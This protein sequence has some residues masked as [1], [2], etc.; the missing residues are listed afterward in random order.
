[1]KN[2]GVQGIG[3]KINQI[4]TPLIQTNDQ[5]NFIKLDGR[6]GPPKL[7]RK[8][9]TQLCPLSVIDKETLKLIQVLRLHTAIDHTVSVT[10]SAVLLRSLVQPRTDLFYIRSKQESLKEIASNAK[11]RKA[12]QDFVH[13]Y[14]RG[15]SALYKFLNKDLYAISP[16]R[17]LKKARQSSAAMVKMMQTIP[18]AETSYLRGLMANLHAYDGSP[19]DQMMRGSIYKTFKGLRSDKQVGLFTPKLKFIP[20][21]FSKWLPA[22]P[23]VAV[24]PYIFNHIGFEPSLSPLMSIIGLAW[25][26]LYLFYSLIVKPVKDTGNFIEPLRA[27]CIHDKAFSRAVDTVGMIDE[28]LS[29]HCW[30]SQ[31]SHATTLPTVT[32]DD[33]HSFEAKGLKNPILAKDNPACVPNDI[34]MRGT[35]LSFISG[36]NSGGKTTICKSIVQNQLLAQMGS[37]VLAEEATINIADMISYQAPKF[38]G[39]QDDEGRFG[40]ELGRTRDIFYATSPRSLVILDELAEGT[41]YEERLHESFGIL[42][43]FHTIGNNTVLVTHNHSLVDRFMAEK[44]GQ[45]LMAAFNGDDPTYKIIPGISRVSHADRITRKIHFSQEDRRQYMQAK[46]Y[47]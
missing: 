45:C 14:R 34:E 6:Q 42:S 1:M 47:L 46:G 11:L 21:R 38:D 17:D 40:T 30:A 43:D 24:A 16:Y 23:A 26:G 29:C 22:G 33:H 36:P 35:R 9:Y 39:L 7:S 37:Y 44:K 41:T 12:L 20:H 19:I 4:Y 25:T 10:G 27:A 28:L 3:E 32:D 15:E 13:E 2:V 8:L 18:R 31:S 5:K